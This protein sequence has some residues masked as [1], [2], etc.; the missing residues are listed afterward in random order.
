MGP[1]FQSAKG[2]RQGD[3]LS[4]TLFNMAGE[5]LTKMVLQAQRNGLFTGLADDLIENGVAILQYADD[6]VLC[7]KHDPEKAINLTHL[8]ELNGSAPC[9]AH[10]AISEC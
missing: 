1:Y 2:V 3:P 8:N 4:P 9:S 6:T 7:I 10:S 5:V